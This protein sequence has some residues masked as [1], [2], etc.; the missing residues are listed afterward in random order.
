MAHILAM[1]SPNVR[2]VLKHPDMRMLFWDRCEFWAVKMGYI[3]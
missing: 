1:S 3:G 2:N